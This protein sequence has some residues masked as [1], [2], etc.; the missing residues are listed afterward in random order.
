MGSLVVS[1]LVALAGCALPANTEDAKKAV[2]ADDPTFQQTLLQKEALDAQ[3]LTLHRQI[4][5]RKRETDARITALQQDY[6]TTKAEAE[7][8]MRGLQAQLTPLRESLRLELQLADNRLKAEQAEVSSL[9]R[10][11]AQLE[12]SLKTLP[13]GASGVDAITQ[14]LNASSAAVGR[15]AAEVQTLQERARLLRLKLQ[16]VQQ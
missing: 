5:Q 15:H 2:L 14:R 4:D 13:A 10:S 11:I 9:R 3:I 8:R 6:R 12:S 16:L 7:A 1:G